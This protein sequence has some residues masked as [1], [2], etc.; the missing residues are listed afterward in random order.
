MRDWLDCL[1]AIDPTGM[2]ADAG[3]EAPEVVADD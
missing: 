3:A 2:P 1:A